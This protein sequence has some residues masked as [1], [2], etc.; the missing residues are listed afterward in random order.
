QPG[1]PAR[2]PARRRHRRYPPD[3]APDS[4]GG[5][6]ASN[7]HLILQGF[8]S[9]SRI[10]PGRAGSGHCRVSRAGAGRRRRCARH[11]QPLHRGEH[12]RHHGRS[13]PVAR[14]YRSVRLRKEGHHRPR[15]SHRQRAS[16]LRRTIRQACGP[17]AGAGVAQIPGTPRSH[18]GDPGTYPAMQRKGGCAHHRCHRP[19]RPVERSGYAGGGAS[20]EGEGDPQGDGG[21]R[22]SQEKGV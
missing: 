1:K 18:T 20:A 7:P 9:D 15:Q 19:R 6:H 17:G 16:G 22:E 2:Y 10:E 11:H 4:G 8:G 14:V 3:S 21:Q 13:T 12:E 5:F